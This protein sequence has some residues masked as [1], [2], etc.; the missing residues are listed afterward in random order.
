MMRGSFFFL[1]ALAIA[2]WSAWQ[3]LLSASRAARHTHS[4]QEFR[5]TW[6]EL[7]PRNKEAWNGIAYSRRVLAD[8]SDKRIPPWCRSSGT[9]EQKREVTER[10][11]DEPPLNARNFSI[12]NSRFPARDAPRRYPFAPQC[13]HSTSKNPPLSVTE[14]MSCDSPLEFSRLVYVAFGRVCSGQ[15][16]PRI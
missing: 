6:Y 15:R 3:S 9:R 16:F 5:P 11:T 10:K 13:C 7:K 4:L 8:K 12:L 14:K 2:S 1:A